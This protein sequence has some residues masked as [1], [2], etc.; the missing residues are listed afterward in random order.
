MNRKEVT[1]TY[2]LIS[3]WKKTTTLVSKVLIKKS[4]LESGLKLVDNIPEEFQ[5]YSRIHIYRSESQLI[6]N[7]FSWNFT[8]TFFQGSG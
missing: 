3:N 4:A 8:K 2:M 6:L 1:K 5:I 7:Q